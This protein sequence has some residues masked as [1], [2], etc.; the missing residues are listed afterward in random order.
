MGKKLLL[1]LLVPAVLLLVGYLYLR[2]SLK[3]AI[4]KEQKKEAAVQPIKDTLGDKKLTTADLRPLFIQRLQQV[5]RKSSN[6]LYDFSVEDMKVD[7]L[8]SSVSL[9]NVTLRPNAQVLQQLKQTGVIPD[10]SFTVSLKSLL[11]EGIN[12]DDAIN[13]KSMD[14]QLLRLVQPVIYIQQHKQKQQATKNDEAFTQDFLKQMK[15]LDIKNLV[16]ENGTII[17]QDQK[18]RQT[19][20]INGVQINMADILLDSST[21]TDPN[22]FL[23]ARKA[24]IR[25]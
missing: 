4:G 11:I 22:R 25:F 6:G 23:F 10:N 5:I 2:L 18:G 14:Y 16:V 21:R 19:M 12:L 8:S 7:V 1:L 15:K 17:S 13:S 24:M 3:A 9:Q 20:R